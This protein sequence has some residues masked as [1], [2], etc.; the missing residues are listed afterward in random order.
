MLKK[1][2]LLLA[3]VLLIFGAKLWFIH[4]FGSPVPYWDQWDG[5]VFL[6]W[7]DGSLTIEHLFSPHNEHRIVLSRLLSLGLLIFN[8]MQWDPLLEMVIN[9]LIS[10]F[11]ALFLSV[12]LYRHFKCHGI[13]FLLIV[14]WIFPYSWE[15]S[16]GGFHSCWYLMT[17]LT[18][19]ALW[20]GLLHPPWTWPW[21]I[22]ILSGVLAYF[23]L[24]SGF[25][26]LVILAMVNLFQ[27]RKT[28]LPTLMISSLFIIL[29]LL[30]FPISTHP[31][32]RANSHLVF[33]QSFAQALSW[34]W[35]LPSYGLLALLTY[36]PFFMFVVKFIRSPSSSPQ[37]R[38]VLGLG[39]WVLL[40]VASMAYARSGVV[41]PRYMDILAL[42]ALSNVLALYF[43]VCHQS[44][45]R[46]W[47]LILSLGVI[48][49]TVTMSP[50]FEQRHLEGLEHLNNVRHFLLTG[51]REYL[52]IKKGKKI[53]YPDSKRLARLLSEPRLRALFSYHLAT[54]IPFSNTKIII[55]K[56]RSFLI[57]S[58]RSPFFN[59]SRRNRLGFL[60]SVR[61][62]SY[63][64]F[65]E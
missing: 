35:L 41:A 8:D 7:L 53:P 54:P 6:L 3:I 14:L 11:T 17:L 60:S 44:L 5:N 56:T 18:L 27:P 1:P 22:G 15:N 37:E 10:T 64:N 51:S 30:I 9:A 52:K 63:R 31:Q 24:A 16:L 26:V 61:A 55:A 48:A 39:G 62:C 13:T 23:N 49:L 34:P 32:F 57:Y 19:F 47:S 4:A 21:W 25:F 42:G 50:Y 58:E 40:Q 46:L 28:E 43:L 59:I 65:Y 12:I 2:F 29:I 38:F 45:I 20:G 33:L 36:L